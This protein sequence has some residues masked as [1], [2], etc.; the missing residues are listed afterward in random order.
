MYWN[1]YG[2]LC[3]LAFITAVRP[4]LQLNFNFHSH[5]VILSTIHNSYCIALLKSALLAKLPWPWFTAEMQ[6]S[7]KLNCSSWRWGAE[8]VELVVSCHHD[9][10]HFVTLVVLLLL[11]TSN[12]NSLRSFPTKSF[13]GWKSYGCKSGP[14]LLVKTLAWTL[15]SGDWDEKSSKED[16]C[17]MKWQKYINIKGKLDKC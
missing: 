15:D 9:K 10:I 2:C 3:M 8:T 11:L 6:K 5:L 17:L 14:Y 7:L 16:A 4:L 12:I 13:M 1:V